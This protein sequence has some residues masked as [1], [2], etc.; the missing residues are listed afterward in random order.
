MSQKTLSRRHELVL[1]SLLEYP[2]V[3]AAAK[4]S[5][6]NPSTIYRYF[7]DETFAREYRKRR[8]ELFTQTTGLLV[9]AS[10]IAVQSLVQMIL[11]TKTADTAKVS[12]CRAVLQ[13][14]ASSQDLDV[15]SHDANL[16]A[17]ELE[18]SKL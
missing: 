4:A 16:L 8:S 1:L 10:A 2:T 14:T 12:A 15:L 5:G 11:D 18:R 7:K 17:E 6:V 9:K 3:T 13:Y